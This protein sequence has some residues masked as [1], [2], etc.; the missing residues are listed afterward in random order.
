MWDFDQSKLENVIYLV[1]IRGGVASAAPAHL[2]WEGRGGWPPAAH[3][4]HVSEHNPG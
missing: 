4:L 2:Q 1:K 3:P